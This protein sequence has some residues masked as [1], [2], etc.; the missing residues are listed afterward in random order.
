VAF[1]VCE[2]P[3]AASCP[4][5]HLSLVKEQEAFDGYQADSLSES[6]GEDAASH[7]GPVSS[8][9]APVDP[10]PWLFLQHSHLVVLIGASVVLQ[11]RYTASPTRWFPTAMQNRAPALLQVRTHKQHPPMRALEAKVNGEWPGIRQLAACITTTKPRAPC[12]GSRQ[13]VGKP[14]TNC[15]TNRDSEHLR[16]KDLGLVPHSPRRC[17][18][19]CT[20]TP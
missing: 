5:F 14:D 10:G 17:N 12:S 8:G 20:I 6:D 19:K 1:L 16:S 3:H 13:L 9:A 11:P 15:I 7:R 2:Q 4:Y 18:G